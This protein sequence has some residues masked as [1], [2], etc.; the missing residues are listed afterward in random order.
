[1]TSE[2]LAP[3]FLGHF[4]FSDSRFENPPEFIPPKNL[5]CQNPDVTI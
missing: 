4:G 2:K 3:P 1:M 5:L